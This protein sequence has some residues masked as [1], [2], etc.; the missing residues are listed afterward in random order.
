MKI[1]TVLDII[2]PQSYDLFH[3]GEC[4]VQRRAYEKF[5]WFKNSLKPTYTVSSALKIWAMTIASIFCIKHA[6]D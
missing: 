2:K 4:H 3:E 6:E 1:I 5:T